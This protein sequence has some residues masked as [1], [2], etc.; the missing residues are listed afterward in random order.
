VIDD[1]DDLPV[2]PYIDADTGKSSGWS[3]S[4]TSRESTHRRDLNGDTETHQTKALHALMRAGPVGITSREFGEWAG[5]EH[6]N[7]S[8]VMSNLHKVDKVCRVSEV[9]KGHEVYVLPQFVEGR[10]T[11]AYKPNTNIING[12][13]IAAMHRIVRTAES[14][15]LDSLPLDL[16]RKILNA[17]QKKETTDAQSD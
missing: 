10:K 13:K 2:L 5:L 7:Y 1:D 15:D 9:R 16:V 6:Q 17:K 3:G 12:K 11:H 8:Q 4:D 14:K